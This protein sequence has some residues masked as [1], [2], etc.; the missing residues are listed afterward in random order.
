MNTLKLEAI[1]NSGKSMEIIVLF[2]IML[3]I[4]IIDVFVNLK[5]KKSSCNG[6]LT[7]KPDTY[8]DFCNMP[9]KDNFF[10]V[11]VFDL[12]H[13]TDTET[14]HWKKHGKSANKLTYLIVDSKL[15]SGY[16][17]RSFEDGSGSLYSENGQK[18][19]EYDMT[20]NQYRMYVGT[21]QDWQEI[22]N[23]YLLR[24]FKTFAEEKIIKM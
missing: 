5:K 3:A 9:Y 11:V 7:V 18:I 2:A 23:G 12:A 15:L 22:P 16:T 13:L 10:H 24:K 19:L 20:H 6:L 14:R 17:W 8:M 21:K 1:K 4:I